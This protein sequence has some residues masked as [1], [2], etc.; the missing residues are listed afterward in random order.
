MDYLE[1]VRL[2]VKTNTA[3]PS[4][5]TASRPNAAQRRCRAN[6][7]SSDN[8]AVELYNLNAAAGKRKN[9]AMQDSAREELL[10]DLLKWLDETSAPLAADPNPT[11]VP[12]K[13]L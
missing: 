5:K 2:S 1:A 12:G 8:S 9:F 11:P 7:R 13:K 10:K 4:P 3:R 6:G